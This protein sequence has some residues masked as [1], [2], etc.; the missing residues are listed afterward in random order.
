MHPPS[1]VID[2]FVTNNT[3]FA[4]QFADGDLATEPAL[5]IAIVTC[6]DSR[7]DMFA[8]LGLGNGEAHVIR[9]AGGVVTDD[10]I[11][12]L[13]LSQRFLKTREIMLVHHTRCGLQMVNEDSFRHELETEVGV[14]PAWTVE[15]FDDPFVDVRQSIHRVLLSPFVPHKETVRGFVYDVDDGRLHEVFDDARPAGN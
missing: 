14:K 15:A 1:T 6:M 4:A 3:D 8:M 11:R 2:T 9:N 10:V 13:C 7:M 12:S 5:R